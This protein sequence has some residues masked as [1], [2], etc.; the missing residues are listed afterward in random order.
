VRYLCRLK[1]IVALCLHV[2]EKTK[3]ISQL[4]TRKITCNKLELVLNGHLV[5]YFFQTHRKQKFVQQK[6]VNYLNIIWK[7][8][9]YKTLGHFK[10][11]EIRTAA[12]HVQQWTQICE[13]CHFHIHSVK[14]QLPAQRISY[15]RPPSIKFKPRRHTSAGSRGHLTKEGTRQQPDGLTRSAQ[16]IGGFISKP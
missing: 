13:T 3:T 11:R 5:C 7:C 12:Y 10:E 2:Y 1:I 15:P 6:T 9:E 4:Q 16:N 14:I 8:S